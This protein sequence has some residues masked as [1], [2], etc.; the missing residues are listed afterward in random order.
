MLFMQISDINREFIPITVKLTASTL[1]VSK[2]IKHDKS[3]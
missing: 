3:L 1:T 2:E